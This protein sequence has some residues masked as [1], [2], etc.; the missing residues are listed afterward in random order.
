MAI[1]IYGEEQ[2]SCKYP[3][4]ARTYISPKDYPSTRYAPIDAI[5][6]ARN[7]W[8]Q[9]TYVTYTDAMQWLHTDV[10]STD[11]SPPVSQKLDSSRLCTQNENGDQTGCD[12]YSMGDR[13]TVINIED[14]SVTKGPNSFSISPKGGNLYQDY[15]TGTRMRNCDSGSTEP[16]ICGF[17]GQYSASTWSNGPTS[18][19]FGTV[20]PV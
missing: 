2:E 11:T 20:S 14:Q 7:S 3:L 8:C 10:V 13:Q 5:Q 15:Q 9:P 4:S 19:D 16:P 17:R 6:Q 12:S 1:Y 18:S